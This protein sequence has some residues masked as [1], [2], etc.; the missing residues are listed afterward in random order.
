MNPG[1]SHALYTVVNNKWVKYVKLD[2]N[3]EGI[4]R[5]LYNIGYI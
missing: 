4:L 1:F 2:I 3:Y 5:V